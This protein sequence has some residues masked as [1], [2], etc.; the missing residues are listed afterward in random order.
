MKIKQFK[1]SQRQQFREW[2]DDNGFNRIPLVENGEDG[3]TLYYEENGQIKGIASRYLNDF[4]PHYQRLDFAIDNNEQ[5][6]C[7]NLASEL[8]KQ[9]T[10]NSL[11]V[12]IMPKQQSITQWQWLIEA[13]NMHPVFI[14]DCPEIDLQSSL[15]A[16]ACPDLGRLR[17]VSYDH[18]TVQEK[19]QLQTFRRAGYVA[20]HTFSPPNPLDNPIWSR[21]DVTQ[22]EESYSFAIFDKDKLLACSDMREYKQGLSL[23]LGWV[24]SEILAT[25]KQTLWT[26]MLIEQLNI[27]ITLNKT[28]WGEFD[29]NSISGTLKKQLL[30]EKEPER[31]IFYNQMPELSK[32]T[33]LTFISFVEADRQKLRDWQAKHNIEPIALVEKGGTTSP[34]KNKSNYTNKGMTLCIEENGVLQGIITRSSN[35]YHPHF[36][37][38]YFAL[39]PEKQSLMVLLMEELLKHDS[40]ETPPLQMT[41]EE[42]TKLQWTWFL[43]RYGFTQKLT[44]DCPEIDIEASLAKLQQP[45][46]PTDYQ[47]LRYDQLNETQSQ[48]LQKFR[49]E[50]YVKTHQ[51]SPPTSLDDPIWSET[52]SSHSEKE[53]SIVILKADNIMACSDLFTWNDELALGWGWS[54]DSLSQ[55]EQLALWKVILVEQLLISQKLKRKFFGEFDS[56]DPYGSLQRTLLV[57]KTEDRFIIL[58]RS[59]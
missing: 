38:L 9:G 47:P 11:P 17:L 7:K 34:L 1:E 37:H 13:F 49:R 28:L 40:A 55:K 4:H 5:A 59:K 12:Q 27:C 32:T 58:Q 30:I 31:F 15:A 54:C 29:L 42:S 50:G 52:D 39:L 19:Q 43:D 56:T 48:A 45:I 18:L 25:L 35:G 33:G 2:Q 57:E 53:N 44:S 8:L 6:L 51:W 3:I 20:T 10:N 36:D 46:L 26:A 22:K 21:T 23:G 41:L 14:S 16:L 24:G